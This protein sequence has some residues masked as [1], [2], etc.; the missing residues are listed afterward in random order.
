MSNRFFDSNQYNYKHHIASLYQVRINKIT[1]KQA[2][3]LILNY[4]G[5]KPTRYFEEFLN[6]LNITEDYFYKKVDQFANKKL[7]KF[8]EKKNKFLRDKENNLIPNKIWF[9]SFND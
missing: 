8:D 7:F 9:D 2:K 4:E 1:K 5:K 6:F 3:D